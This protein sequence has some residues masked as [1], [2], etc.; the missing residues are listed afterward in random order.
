MKSQTGHLPRFLIA[1]V[2]V[3]APL[4]A[5]ENRTA[6]GRCPNVILFKLDPKT[7]IPA[8]EA[9]RTDRHFFHGMRVLSTLH[10]SDAA[11]RNTVCE[12]LTIVREHGDPPLV[13]DGEYG[14]RIQCDDRKSMNDLVLC[15]HCLS[16]RLRL[17]G[18][19]LADEKEITLK[20]DDE[21]RL[22][23]ALDRSFGRSRRATAAPQ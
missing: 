17:T 12:S 3:A 23:E 4:F 6:S 20:D 8:E 22:R 5:G 7:E 15:F 19:T 10:V 18:K 9:N 21:R 16:P 11:L 1:F 2:A 13:R 14:I